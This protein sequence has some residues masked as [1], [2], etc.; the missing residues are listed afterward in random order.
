MEYSVDNSL[1]VY[2][3]NMVSRN[4]LDNVNQQLISAKTSADHF[5]K[6]IEDIKIE[7]AK[8][9]SALLSAS[10]EIQQL[11]IEIAAFRERYISLE[12]KEKALKEEMESIGKKFSDQFEVL[13][14]K[15]LEERVKSL[16]KQ[17]QI[18]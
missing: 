6:T 16:Q 4:A 2:W 7:K 15:I 5:A 1:F 12:E 13:A 14:N 18:I 9:E 3:K 8:T 17:I 11:Q 10:G